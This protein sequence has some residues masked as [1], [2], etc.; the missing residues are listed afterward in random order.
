MP[1]FLLLLKN[2]KMEGSLI[3]SASWLM[4]DES[5]GYAE[6]A[7]IILGFLESIMDPRFKQPEV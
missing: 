7:C 3:F 2:I 5:N 6:E 1:P 4:E